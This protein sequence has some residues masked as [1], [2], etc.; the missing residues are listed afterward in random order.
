MFFVDLAARGRRAGRRGDRGAALRTRTA[1]ACSARSRPRHNQRQPR[2]SNTH[3][4]TVRRSLAGGRTHAIVTVPGARP[5]RPPPRR[6]RAR[7][8]V[9]P[10]TCEILVKPDERGHPAETG[11]LGEGGE[12][13][14]RGVVIALLAPPHRGPDAGVPEARALRSHAEPLRALRRRSL[15]RHSACP[16]LPAPDATTL[17]MATAAAKTIAART[18][19]TQSAVSCALQAGSHRAVPAAP[20]LHS[21]GSWRLQYHQAEQ[22]LCR[23]ETTRGTD[24]IRRP[25]PLVWWSCP[26]AQRD[27]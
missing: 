26:G 4:R 3:L 5:R 10:R 11:P 1:C 16:R 21:A 8:A 22:G 9:A 18:R 12:R 2:R 23:S 19:P 13:G 24:L 15:A 25:W 14:V 20:R 7:P 27:V 17:A 6:W